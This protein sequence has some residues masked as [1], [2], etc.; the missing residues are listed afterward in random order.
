MAVI[1]LCLEH[2]CAFDKMPPDKPARDQLKPTRPDNRPKARK[3]RGFAKASSLMN[4]QIQ[5]ASETRGFASSRLLTQWAEV[6]G[7]SIAKI[8]RPLKVTYSREGIGATLLLLTNGANAPIVE[9][10]S[11]QIKERVNSCYGYNAIAR[12]KITQTSPDG[13]DLGWQTGA[14]TETTLV[15]PPEKIEQAKQ[16]CAPIEDPTLKQ[17]LEDLGSHILARK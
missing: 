17:A 6:A 3:S 15:I 8:A 1:V 2:A 14:P 16:V 5:T 11:Q 13:L 12:V 7:P 9:A 10:Q 4:K